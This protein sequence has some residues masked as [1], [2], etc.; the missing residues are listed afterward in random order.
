MVE[1]TYGYHVVFF[2]G[3]GLPAWQN[4]AKDGYISEVMTKYQ[5]DIIKTYK[6]SYDMNE[7]KKIP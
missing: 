4:D 6:V 2:I 7:I 5:E 3:N 1:T